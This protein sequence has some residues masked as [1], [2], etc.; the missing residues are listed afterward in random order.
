MSKV[1]VIYKPQGENA[2]AVED[3]MRDFYRQTGRELEVL[4]P[5][6]REG[7][8][9]CR[10]YDI[11]E[12]PSMLAMSDDGQLQNSWRG[13]PLPTINEVSYYN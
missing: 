8:D 13:L 1:I 6:S 5:E 9:M 4:D 7:A 11:V 10:V 2:R 12:Y 3:Y